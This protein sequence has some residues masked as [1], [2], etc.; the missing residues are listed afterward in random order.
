MLD[1]ARSL[2][3]AAA[4]AGCAH[5]P[6]PSTPAAPAAPAHHAHWSYE[7]ATGPEHWGALDPAFAACGDGRA[8]SP[9]D[10]AGATPAALP[11]LGFHYVPSAGKVVDN[12]HT[13]QID[14]AP[15]SW[16]DLDGA[17]YPLVQFHFHHPSEHTV[18]GRRAPLE[19]HLVHK[20]AGGALAVIGVLV[21]SGGAPSALA[22]IF[23]QLPPPGGARS[24]DAPFSPEA[25]LPAER[26]YDRYVGSLT[27]PPCTEGVRWQVLRAPLAISAGEIDAFSARYPLDSRPLQPRHDRPLETSAR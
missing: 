22:P 19:L 17:R 14:L 24:L 10:L 26:A 1:G 8:Q 7:G 3:L 18:D 15:G 11:A 25:I 2:V 9:I 20:T 13:I 6:S 4:L 21:E 27:A 5:A 23:A 12:G 16:L